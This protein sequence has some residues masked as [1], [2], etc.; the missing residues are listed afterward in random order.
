MTNKIIIN[1]IVLSLLLFS[2]SC[3][4]GGNSKEENKP[5]KVSSNINIKPTA[6]FEDKNILTYEDVVNNELNHDTLNDIYIGDCFILKS[7]NYNYGFT[8][9]EMTK[10]SYAMVPVKLDTNKTG[11]QMFKTGTVRMVGAGVYKYPESMDVW[12]EKEKIEFLSG[13]KKIGNLKL[14]ENRP[15][16]KAYGTMLKYNL[17]EFKD[18]IWYQNN[19]YGDEMDDMKVYPSL[20]KLLENK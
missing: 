3:S 19:T 10:S 1:L 7:D 4:N 12:N 13:F 11:V 9:Y 5:Q 15:A 2:I 18:F 16:V 17:K 20:E 14:I 8:L 6:T